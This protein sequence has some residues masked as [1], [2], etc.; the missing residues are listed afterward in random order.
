MPYFR[1][2]GVEFTIRRFPIS[3]ARGVID[4]RDEKIS[5]SHYRQRWEKCPNQPWQPLSQFGLSLPKINNQ[6]TETSQ[7]RNKCFRPLDPRP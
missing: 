5:S 2:K 7:T 6:T 3:P 1:L 4:T